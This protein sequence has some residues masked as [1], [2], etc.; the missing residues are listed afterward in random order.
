MLGKM[1]SNEKQGLVKIRLLNYIFHLKKFKL[2]V[3]Y[4][5]IILVIF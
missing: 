2:Y 3:Y 4:V 5:H 1:L